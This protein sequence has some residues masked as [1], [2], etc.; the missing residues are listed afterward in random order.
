MEVAQIGQ[1]GQYMYF[2]IFTG[3]S[4]T[5]LALQA[6]KVQSIAWESGGIPLPPPET[7]CIYLKDLYNCQLSPYPVGIVKVDKIK[8][9]GNGSR[10]S[11]KIQHKIPPNFMVASRAIIWETL[12]ALLSLY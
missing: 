8:L 10:G 4:D 5:L 1:K 12:L 9:F 11:A 2:K 7:S 6:P 3:P